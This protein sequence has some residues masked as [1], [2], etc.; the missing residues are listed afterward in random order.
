MKESNPFGKFDSD[1]IDVCSDIIKS[2]RTSSPKN[3]KKSCQRTMMQ[4]KIIRAILNCLQRREKISEI[5]SCKNSKR[6]K[7]YRLNYKENL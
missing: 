2:A 4:E 1:T 7:V 5:S 3:S 6:K